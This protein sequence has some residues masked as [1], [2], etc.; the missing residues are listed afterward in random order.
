MWI[1]NPEMVI[2][3]WLSLTTTTPLLL[4][5]ACLKLY[6]CLLRSYCV[7]D[8]I[9]CEFHRSKDVTEQKILIWI[10]MYSDLVLDVWKRHFPVSHYKILYVRLVSD[11]SDK[12]RRRY[13][14][15]VGVCYEFVYLYWNK[16]IFIKCFYPVSN[17]WGPDLPSYY[18]V[19]VSVP[20]DI[21]G[22]LSS[23]SSGN[24]GWR[25]PC[26]VESPRV[27]RDS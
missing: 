14:A 25:L 20:P 11:I 9:H 3:I 4:T 18:W 7:R 2:F 26:T 1:K 22:E 8:Y 10:K 5:C 6:C 12:L 21:K 23:V 15:F 27:R 16:G 19:P 24:L 13:R 17:D